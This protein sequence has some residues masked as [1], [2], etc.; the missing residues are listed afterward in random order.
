M[1]IHASKQDTHTHKI[2]KFKIIKCKNIFL[3]NSFVEREAGIIMCPR[4]AK[5]YGYLS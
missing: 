5:D 4:E 3:V 1:E 2:H